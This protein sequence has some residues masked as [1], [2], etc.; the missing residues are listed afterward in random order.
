MNEFFEEYW[1]RNNGLIDY[2]LID[3]ALNFAW[4]NNL[5]G[6]KDFT[7][8]NF[9]KNN[10]NLFTLE[11]LLNKKYDDNIWIQNMQNTEMYKLTYK[12]KLSNNKNTYY[13]KIVKLED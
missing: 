13:N 2:F 7:Q 3:Y 10:P 12:I 8:K 11:P 1:N 6:F 4:G 9:K 5:S